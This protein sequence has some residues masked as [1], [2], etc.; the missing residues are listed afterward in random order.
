MY[1]LH[2]LLSCTSS[3]RYE[4]VLA[5]YARTSLYK[6]LACTRPCTSSRLPH[7]CVYVA[8]YDQMTMPHHG[9]LRE[10]TSAHGLHDP[11]RPAPCGI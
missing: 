7:K 5:S 6:L 10:L 2:N 1:D 9:L 4:L 11:R 8:S 3:H